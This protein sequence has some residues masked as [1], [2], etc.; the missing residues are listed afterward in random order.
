MTIKQL[1]ELADF[2]ESIGVNKHAF[3]VALHIAAD[4]CKDEDVVKAYG[5]IACDKI[6][7][8]YI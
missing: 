8:W 1:K 7:G 5:T 4:K 6:K 3:V 2:A